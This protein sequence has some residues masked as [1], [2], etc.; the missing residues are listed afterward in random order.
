MRA[1][2]INH[3]RNICGRL[4]HLATQTH[5]SVEKCDPN[6]SAGHPS[7]KWFCKTA[8]VGFFDVS[9]RKISNFLD[10]TGAISSAFIVANSKFHLPNLAA[11]ML[12]VWLSIAF[13]FP[14]DIA[15]QLRIFVF[16]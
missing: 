5:L 12:I 4:I 13:S 2:E 3:S 6:F 15:G 8:S 16:E 11:V 10:V 1:V 7:L 9:Y 14:A